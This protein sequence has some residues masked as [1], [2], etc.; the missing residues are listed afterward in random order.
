MQ[1]VTATIEAAAESKPP[2]RSPYIV[3]RLYDGIFFIFS[4]LLALLLGVAISGTPLAKNEVNLWGHKGSVTN[5]FIG[6]FIFAHLVIVF[7]RSH[8]NRDIFK[9]HP[10]RFTVVPVALFAA[11]VASKWILV[12]MAVLAIWWDVYH[13][14]LQ[15]FGL[16]RIYD[17]KQGSNPTQGRRLDYILNL[18]LYAGPIVGGITLYDHMNQSFDS[19]SS[20][21]SVFLTSIP[22]YAEAYHRYLTMAVVGFAVPF[23]AYYLFAYWRM[24]R[25][26]YKVSKDSA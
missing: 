18:L 7:F 20:L 3:G 14:S 4:P 22:A 23:L 10:V 11:M 5:I 15:T 1:A 21:G 2:A 24:S 6:A 17:A 13:S 16:G 26:G 25:S 8:G 9:L 19:F 12:S